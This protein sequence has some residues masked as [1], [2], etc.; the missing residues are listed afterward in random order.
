MQIQGKHVP[1][2]K[3]GQCQGQK[4]ELAWRPGAAWKPVRLEWSKRGGE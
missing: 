1:G 2:S 4:W 3:N